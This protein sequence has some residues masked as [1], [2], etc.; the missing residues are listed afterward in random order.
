MSETSTENAEK[1]IDPGARRGELDVCPVCG[2]SVHPQAYFC[3]HCTNY[4]CFI[5]R[6]RVTS[7]DVLLQCV[8]RDCEYFGKMVC[9]QCDLS[10]TTEEKPFLYKEPTDGYWPAWLLVCI[11]L[12]IYVTWRTTF[13]LGGLAFLALYPGLGYLLQAAGLNIFGKERSVEFPRSKT[14]YSCV[15]CAQPAKLITLSQKT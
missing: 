1:A 10:Q 14:E 12:S 5:C 9:T 8:N 15:R 13:L 4:F 11:L 7:S 3:S 6:S 2:S